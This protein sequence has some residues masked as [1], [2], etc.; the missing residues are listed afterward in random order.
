MGATTAFVLF[1]VLVAELV[2]TLAGV[3]ATGISGDAAVAS[4]LVPNAVIGGCCGV[5][6]AV[7]GPRRRRVRLRAQGRPGRADRARHPRRS[8]PSWASATAPKP[9]C[10]PAARGSTL[11]GAEDRA[12]HDDPGAGAKAVAGDNART[13]RGETTT[14]TAAVAAALTWPVIA[15]AG[16]AVGLLVLLVGDVVGR[17]VTITH[18][19]GHMVVGLLT[20][21]RV[22]H[23][24][25][26]ADREG[27]STTFRPGPGWPGSIVTGFAGYATPPL[28]GLGGAVLL[29]KGLALPV[30]WI[31][32]FLLVLAWVQ[33]RDEVTSVV[34]LVIAGF[35]AYV[36]LYG[37]AVLKA[38]FAA[39]L[40]LLLLFGGLRSAA[41]VDLDKT[42]G[43][44]PVVLARQTWIPAIVWKAAFVAIA[45]LCLLK[46]LQ[47]LVR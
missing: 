11:L 21:G 34:V 14:V 31:A 22:D 46:G 29:K 30:L 41:L 10:W 24:K 9:R 43:S 13:D 7:I 27:G 1:A 15:A 4:Y 25:L 3:L 20:G 45:L 5:C 42:S 39:G 12:E 23:F 44:D 6:G 16:I 35:L 28:L 17:I 37:T 32:V 8:S 2:A 40:V 38:A 19:G 47:V 36:A 26:N 33:A 18:E